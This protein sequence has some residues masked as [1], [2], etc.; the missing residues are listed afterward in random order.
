MGH[1]VLSRQVQ[2][3]AQTQLLEFQCFAVSLS[4]CVV[5]SLTGQLNIGQ[6]GGKHIA[7]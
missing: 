2:K 5:I 1:I 3:L 6:R 7:D 4:L